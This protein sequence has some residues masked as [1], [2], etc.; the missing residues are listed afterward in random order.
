MNDTQSIRTDVASSAYNAANNAPSSPTP[1][2]QS[3]RSLL[4]DTLLGVVIGLA[5]CSILELLISWF[6]YDKGT[7]YA[8]VPSFLGQFDDMN[9]AV[10]VERL[11]YALIGVVSCLAARIYNSP[12][13]TLAGATLIHVVIILTCVMAAALILQ[14]IPMSAA[15]IVGMVLISLVAYAIIWLVIWLITRRDVKLANKAIQN[16][17]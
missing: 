1:P 17:R 10:A 4:A 12:R 15:A 9:A 11:V 3:R 6:L 14:W 8:G 16:R 13:L 7:Y 5:V 2:A